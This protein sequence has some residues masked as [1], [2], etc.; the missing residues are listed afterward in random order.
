MVPCNQFAGPTAAQWIVRYQTLPHGRQT[1]QRW[2]NAGEERS[3]WFRYPG[4]F[5]QDTDSSNRNTPISA[6]RRA[7][8]LA[9]S[10]R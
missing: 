4:P 3:R 9:L 2:T 1:A 10:V 5:S 8:A 6:I 7:M